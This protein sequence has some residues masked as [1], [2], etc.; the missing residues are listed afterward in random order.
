MNQ[1]NNKKFRGLSHTIVGG[2]WAIGSASL[3]PLFS[4]LL[5]LL[6]LLLLLSATLPLLLQSP[7]TALVKFKCSELLLLLS[8]VIAAIVLGTLKLSKEIFF[9]A[10]SS[11]KTLIFLRIMKKI[12]IYLSKLNG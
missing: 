7:V 2:I 1:L 10:L 6:L 8:M 12:Y 4:M 11:I 3:L 9:E 5:P